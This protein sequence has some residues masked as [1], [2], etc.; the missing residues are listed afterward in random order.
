MIKLF[1][2]S[3]FNIFDALNVGT[4]RSGR[5]TTSPVPGFL[6][7]FGIKG[8]ASQSGVFSR[9]TGSTVKLPVPK[10]C[11]RIINFGK[12]GKTKFLSYINTKGEAILHEYSDY[13]L[14]QAT[15]KI[16]KA[17]FTTDLVKANI[18]K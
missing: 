15:Y 6:A 17:V 12:T 1:V 5:Y 4:Y 8:C 3:S 2:T 13:G 9:W 18:K 7:F 14:L 10:D 11:V 16:D